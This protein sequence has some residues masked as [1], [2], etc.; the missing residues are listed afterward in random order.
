MLGASE[1]SPSPLD[2]EVDG[3]G[4]SSRSSSDVEGPA[5]VAMAAAGVRLSTTGTEDDVGWTN[6]GATHV[7][8]V[9][10]SSCPGDK[11]SSEY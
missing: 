8:D 1:Y 5:A 3:D 11:F 6:I 9:I 4:A 10:S 7:S 2:G